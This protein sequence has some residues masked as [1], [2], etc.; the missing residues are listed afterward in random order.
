MKIVDFL[1]KACFW[2]SPDS[3]GTHCIIQ[4]LAI[5]EEENNDF[6]TFRMFLALSFNHNHFVILLEYFISK[7]L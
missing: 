1:I 5:F 3:P 7:N 4:F 6:L 2:V